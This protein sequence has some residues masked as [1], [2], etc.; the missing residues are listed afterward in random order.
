MVEMEEILSQEEV[1]W[2]QK[3]RVKWTAQEE[4]NTNYFTAS[5]VAKWRKWKFIQL[6]DHKEVWSKDEQK[7]KSLAM[8]YYKGLS[9]Q[10]IIS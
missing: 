7:L 3:A 1:F 2:Q 9:D 8:E 10:N 6:R 4:R 5:I